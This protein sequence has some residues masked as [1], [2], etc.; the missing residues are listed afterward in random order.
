MASRRCPLAHRVGWQRAAN[1]AVAARSQPRFGASDENTGL[2][3]AHGLPPATCREPSDATTATFYVAD[4]IGQRES[5]SADRR[6]IPAEASG[7]AIIS[8]KGGSIFTDREKVPRPLVFPT[9]SL[10]T[11]KESS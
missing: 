1:S 8:S 10:W 11:G 6:S 2:S 4:A 7:A 5:P 9:L 3:E